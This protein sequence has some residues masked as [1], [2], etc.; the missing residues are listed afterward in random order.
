MYVFTYIYNYI[1]IYL[2]V[3]IFVHTHVYSYIF[4]YTFVVS[5]NLGCCEDIPTWNRLWCSTV[6]EDLNCD[7]PIQA[8]VPR[9]GFHKGDQGSNQNVMSID[10][11]FAESTTFFMTHVYYYLVTFVSLH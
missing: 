10:K 5:P 3:Y 4:V 7:I 6:L 9:V 1:Y 8:A 2:Y 11:D